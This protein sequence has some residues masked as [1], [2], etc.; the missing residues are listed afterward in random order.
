MTPATHHDPEPRLGRPL[1]AADERRPLRLVSDGAGQADRRGRDDELEQPERVGTWRWDP[2]SDRL[3]W[4]EELCRIYGRSADDPARTYGEFLAAVHPDDREDTERIVERAFLSKKT[5]DYR[6]RIVL[7]DGRAR[8]LQSVIHVDLDDEG[9]VRL[10]HGSCQDVTDVARVEESP[11]RAEVSRDIAGAVLGAAHDLNN[12]LA[13]IGAE[14][15]TL[16]R[17][18]PPDSPLRTDLKVLRDAA[19][20][21]SALTRNLLAA[22]RGRSSEP[23]V[24]DVNEAVVS[25]RP[26][27]EQLVGDDREL[28]VVL[29]RDAGRVSADS[30][31][32]D[33]IVMNLV[34]N[35]RDA[36]PAGEHI[37]VA[38]DSVVDVGGAAPGSYAR[39]VVTDSGSGMDER[40]RSRAMDPFF[41]TKPAFGTGLGL[42]TVTD[43]AE[44]RGGTVTV[45]SEPGEGTRVEVRLPRLDR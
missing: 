6:H 10:L 19:N 28:S 17:A 32:I 18:A 5:V 44:R 26:L 45:A 43:L 23:G 21:A 42:S 11:C 24:V 40:T 2:Q 8:V 27:L 15:E 4:S 34:L 41:T 31:E 22:A 25:L 33:Q 38:T 14:A 39:I 16:V 35:A 29:G 30:I 7:P 37:R 13:M 1:A 3:E 9:N 20:R 36:V 12:L